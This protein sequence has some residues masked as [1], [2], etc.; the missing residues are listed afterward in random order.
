MY[1]SD[2]VDYTDHGGIRLYA[3]DTVFHISGNNFDKAVLDMNT[4]AKQSWNWCNVKKLKINLTKS[5]TLLLS[6][7]RRQEHLEL[8]NK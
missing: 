7:L 4:A 6:N 8:K 3:D 2:L 5:K 1:I